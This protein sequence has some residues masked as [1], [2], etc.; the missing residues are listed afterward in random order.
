MDF[1]HRCQ[2]KK[3]EVMLCHRCSVV[4]DKKAAKKVENT[5]KA[6][7]KE[8]EKKSKPQYYFNKRG[9]PQ[10]KEQALGSQKARPNTYKP[11]VNAP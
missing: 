2:R 3:S 10:R 4:F 6:R 7:E 1:L 11:T 9:V 5:Q 8:N